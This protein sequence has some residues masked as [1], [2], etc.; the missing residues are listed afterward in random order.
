MAFEDI[1]FPVYRKYKNGKNLFKILS[2]DE[3]EELQVVG[4]KVILK[5]TRA[6][7][8]PELLFVQDMLLNF[9]PMADESTPEEFDELK[10][11]A[12]S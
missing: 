12:K 11:R 10:D 5:K 9:H 6:T 1:Q 8:Y 3:F 7:Q 2:P 4:S